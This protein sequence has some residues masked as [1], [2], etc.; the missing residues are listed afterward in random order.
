MADGVIV[1]E[2]VAVCVRDGVRLCVD[3]IVRVLL[4]LLLRERVCVSDGVT[5]RD[6]VDVDVFE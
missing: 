2:C 5:D 6:R 1:C 4:R 3:E